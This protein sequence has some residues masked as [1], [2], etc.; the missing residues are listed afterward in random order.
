MRNTPRFGL[1]VFCSALALAGPSF[2][3]AAERPS[4]KFV[5]VDNG[6]GTF[7]PQLKVTQ[8][9]GDVSY[10]QIGEN[11]LTRT[12]LYDR[13]LLRDFTQ[14]LNRKAERRKKKK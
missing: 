9:N 2:S 6:T 14:K 5:N 3:Q 7:V 1:I 12:I 8:P 11:G 4:Y 10:M 13:D